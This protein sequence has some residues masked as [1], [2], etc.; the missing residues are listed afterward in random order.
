MEIPSFS[1]V[2]TIGPVSPTGQKRYYTRAWTW[3]EPHRC[4]FLFRPPL[5]ALII[6]RTISAAPRLWSLDC[7]YRSL[8]FSISFSCVG[9]K[10]CERVFTPTWSQHNNHLLHRCEVK[11]SW[12]C[13][14]LT[15]YLQSH[16]FVQ[17]TFHSWTN[18]CL[19]QII[20]FLKNPNVL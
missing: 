12:S 10:L 5:Q 7:W 18:V 17:N 11:M 6:C 2:E 4:A 9:D 19:F 14:V 16:R 13:S 20:D 15:P 1:V 3:C 8:C